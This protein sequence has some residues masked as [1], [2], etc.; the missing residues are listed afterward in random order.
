LNTYARIGWGIRMKI[1]NE[2]MYITIQELLN[3]IL[4]FSM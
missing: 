3:V 2:R 1:R 4:S